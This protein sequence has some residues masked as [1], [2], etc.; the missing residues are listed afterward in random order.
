M[1]HRSLISNILCID[2]LVFIKGLIVDIP[3]PAD[4]SCILR[5]LSD[6]ERKVEKMVQ[7]NLVL[8]AVPSRSSIACAQLAYRDS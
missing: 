2:E 4:G 7:R 3:T 5:L 8:F 6:R 1:L